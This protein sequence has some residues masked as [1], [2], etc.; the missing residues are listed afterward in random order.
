METAVATEKSR[1]EEEQ[2]IQ[3]ETLRNKQNSEIDRLRQDMD[4]RHRDKQD[5]LRSQLADNQKEV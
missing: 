5:D 3:V 4:K 2:R 1:L